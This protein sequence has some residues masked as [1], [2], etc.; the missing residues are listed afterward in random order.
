MMTQTTLQV[1][2]MRCA[3]CVASVEKG[4]RNTP[5]VSDAS[6]NLATGD[7][8]VSH[9]KSQVDAAQLVEAVSKA[10]Y[11][12]EAGE[13]EAA[14]G[15]THE[16]GDLSLRQLLIA[17]L[18]AV[19]IMALA[20]IRPHA[21]WSHWVQFALALPLQIWLGR[22]FYKGAWQAAK[23][24]RA[25][26]DTLVALSTTVAF[27]Y[28][29]VAT[30][31]GFGTVY[32]ETAVMILVLIG[33]GRVLEG[34]ARRRAGD[35]IRGLM[36]LQPAEAQVIRNGETKTIAVSEIR[37]GD[38]VRV[39][40][41]QRVPVDGKVVD[42]ESTIDKS[43]VT[44]ESEPIEIGK[45]DEV[46][47]GTLNQT[48]A[49]TVEA[50]ATGKSTV[51]SQIIEMVRRAQASK[52]RIQRIVDRV[53]GV[54]VPIVVAI[55]IVAL[56]GWWITGEPVYGLRAMIAVLIVACPCAL[57]LA[58]PTAM[59]V[60]TGLG[61]KHGIL[62][63]DASVLE[64]A[65][66]LTHVILDKTGTLTVGRASVSD[67]KRIEYASNGGE[68]GA[69]LSEEEILQLAASVET[70]SEHPLGKALVNYAYERG[71]E[72]S[73][74]SDFQSITAGGVRGK[75]D[76]HEVVVGRF[77]T[78][79]EE[80][81]SDLDEVKPQWQQ[82]LEEARTAVMVAVDGRAVALIGYNDTIKPEAG[83]IVARLHKAKLRVTMMTGDHE[84]A[85]KR[86]A[87]Q[88]GIDDVMAEVVPSEKQSKVESLR[89]EGKVVAMVGDGINDAP[90]LAAADLGIAMGGGEEGKGGGTDI[91]M[92]AGDVVIVGGQLVGV[93]RAISLSRATMRRIWIGLFWAFIYNLVLIPFAAF[94]IIHPMIAAAAMSL[95]SVSVVGNALYL[96][97]SWKPDKS[98]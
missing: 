13:S 42:G 25:E 5:G 71:I 98:Y 6:V 83:D 51:L 95:S 69:G 41:G 59:M 40:P 12:A 65:G 11:E 4:L 52:A 60:G 80:G 1:H 86:V 10:G 64:R 78:L 19:A 79:R 47:G 28:S 48:G 82:H 89:N 76:G 58:T 96:R 55:S 23:S 81:V 43:M 15:H 54:F 14:G 18:A 90:A 21:N 39:R 61:A 91:A 49:F 50:T 29:V 26:M 87:E 75:V 97:W 85:A 72:L 3:G 38:H 31:A 74:V 20:M 63:K 68:D 73:D 53:A 8:V 67:V 77:Q 34:R 62:I 56:A 36:E 84:A 33:L 92:D 66:Q 70:S 2:G 44:G 88:V 32:F 45:H 37:Q 46:I 35:A 24:G 30:V 93:P 22:P 16:T 7:A 17:G 9:D 57:G 94:N 27:G